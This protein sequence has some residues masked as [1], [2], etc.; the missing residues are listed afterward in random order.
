MKRT[1]IK[2]VKEGDSIKIVEVNHVATFEDIA[3]R[4]GDKIAKMYIEDAPSYY[5]RYI[6]GKRTL[7]VN[8]ENLNWIGS[9]RMPDDGSLCFDADDFSQFISIL[10]AAGNRLIEIAKANQPEE[11][12]ILI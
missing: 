7:T 1:E 5:L 12:T 4:Y 6:L 8:T 10:K 11:K 9:Y 2:Y 3:E